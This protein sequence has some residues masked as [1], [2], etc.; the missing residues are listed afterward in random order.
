MSW[1]INP[2][3]PVPCLSGLQRQASNHAPI[4]PQRQL[5][6]QQEEYNMQVK[7]VSVCSV[8][9]H[10]LRLSQHVVYKPYSWQRFESLHQSSATLKPPVG[11]VKTTDP[12]TTQG[13]CGK[14]VRHRDIYEQPKRWGRPK[15]PWCRPPPAGQRSP[16]HHVV[17]NGS[18][19]VK[20]SLRYWPRI[21]V[22]TR[23]SVGCS[24]TI[25]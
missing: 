21:S 3:L 23:A 6:L 9:G 22:C 17:R 4:Q 5:A 15:T 25:S 2:S 19:S 13:T 1:N 8:C 16:S 11:E 7:C 14:S 24:G 10:P 12:V 20:R 18:R